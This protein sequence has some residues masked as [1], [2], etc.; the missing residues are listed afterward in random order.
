MPDLALLG[1]CL[2]SLHILCDI[3]RSGTVHYQS[4][5]TCRRAM[6]GRHPF[7]VSSF[8]VAVPQDHQHSDHVR[9]RPVALR[10]PGLPIHLLQV[11]VSSM[12]TNQEL[13]IWSARRIRCLLPLNEITCTGLGKRMGPRLRESRLLAPSGRQREFTQPSLRLFLH[14]C[15]NLAPRPEPAERQNHATYVV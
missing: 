12:E 13:C 3:L 8:F 5:S 6:A 1:S 7:T 9:P 2:V 10:A 15:T 4:L 14:I 11:Q